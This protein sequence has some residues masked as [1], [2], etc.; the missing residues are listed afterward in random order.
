MDAKE[1]KKTES[2]EKLKAPEISNRDHRHDK[3]IAVLICGGAVLVLLGLGAGLW[4]H[5]DHM[6]GRRLSEVKLGMM[7]EGGFTR[8]PRMGLEKGESI[9]PTDGSTVSRLTG[10]VTQVGAD[11]F[12]IA[13]N[14]TTKTIKTTATTD[15]NTTD[16]KV[17]VNDT[18]M[19][20]GTDSNGT[21]TATA[22]RVMN[23]NQ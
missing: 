2:A 3:R 6:D 22:V 14:G 15:Y 12:T 16:K 13:G 8:G 9:N 11:S 21:F 17:S 19:V 1:V 10:V 7:E 23:A 20:S 18:V 5:H 4:L